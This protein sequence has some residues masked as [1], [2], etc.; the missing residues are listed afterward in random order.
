[1]TQIPEELLQSFVDKFCLIVFLK[2]LGGSNGKYL[3]AAEKSCAER[4]SEIVLMLG[5]LEDGESLKN[6]QRLKKC[7]KVSV[8]PRKE[9]CE[10]IREKANREWWVLY[11]QLTD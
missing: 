11:R 2:G 8:Y 6:F 1:M 4:E 9:K 10:G 7:L 3:K 5:T